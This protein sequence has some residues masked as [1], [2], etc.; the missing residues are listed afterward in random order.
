MTIDEINVCSHL[1]LKGDGRREAGR[2]DVSLRYF[3]LM[4]ILFGTITLGLECDVTKH[5]FLN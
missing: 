1:L 4:R 3:K 2:P 5:W